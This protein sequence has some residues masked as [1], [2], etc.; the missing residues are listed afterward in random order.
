MP[1][2][3]K[4]AETPGHNLTIHLIA[5]FIEMMGHKAEIEANF[6][7]YIAD[8]FDWK[9]GLAYEI[10]TANNPRVE[11]SKVD[12]ALLHT[13]INDVIF[14][15]TKGFPVQPIMNT[16]WYKQIKKKIIG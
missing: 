4:R 7:D 8:V 14:I 3:N 13:E 5:H 10:Q 11:K 15:Y 16:F 12:M 9:T 1:V 2:K 6:G